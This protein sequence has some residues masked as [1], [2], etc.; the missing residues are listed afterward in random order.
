MS[1]T[2]SDGNRRSRT[3]TYVVQV[4]DFLYSLDLTRFIFPFGYIE[5]V[6]GRQVPDAIAEYCK[7]T[8]KLK[9]FEMEKIIAG[10]DFGALGGMVAGYVRNQLRW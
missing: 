5:H 4:T 7:D 3:E 2:D 9:S 6:D 8:N 10:F 1:Y